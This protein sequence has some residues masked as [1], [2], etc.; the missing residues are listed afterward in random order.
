MA[1]QPKTDCS[2]KQT[3]TVTSPKKFAVTFVNG[4]YG[5]EEV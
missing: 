2:V 3:L 1:I 5:K 4:Y